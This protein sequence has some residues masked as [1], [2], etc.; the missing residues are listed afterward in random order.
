[1]SVL[2]SSYLQYLLVSSTKSIPCIINLGTPTFP[3]RMDL[4]GNI[5]HSNNDLQVR[6]SLLNITIIIDIIN[7]HQL[8]L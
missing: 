2:I 4:S 7:L 3:K 8:F 5:L 1:M 6:C